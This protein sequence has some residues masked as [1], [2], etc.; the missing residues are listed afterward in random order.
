MFILSTFCDRKMWGG[1]RLHTYN[2]DKSLNDI[3]HVYTVS[4]NEDFTC[5][6]L[7]GKFKGKTLYEVYRDHRDLFGYNKYGVFP[8]IIGF[9]DAIGD[10][11]VQLHP[12]DAFAQ[13][14]LNKEIGKIE[15]WYFITPPTNGYIYDGCKQ[16]TLDA[17]KEKVNDKRWWDIIDTI[18]VKQGDYVFV[19]SGTVHAIAA[20]SLVYEIQQSTDVTYRFWDYDRLDPQGN[21]RE[22]QTDTCLEILDPNKKSVA[23][24]MEKE[25]E[26]VER[27][28]STKR[29]DIVDGYENKEDVFCCVTLL[30][31]SI[32]VDGMHLTRGQSF[33]AL[34][35]EKV[36]FTGKAEVIVALPR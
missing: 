21:L 7:N 24:P 17:V 20:G 12:D 1:T 11:S 25:K 27:E 34:P 13:K 35:H 30:D 16:P 19:D 18:H 33:I 14:H 23:V 5:E 28:Y 10:L 26:F 31:G 2:G 8:I 3:A 6:I 36:D 29:I 22:L 4:A 15:S 32:D 9:V